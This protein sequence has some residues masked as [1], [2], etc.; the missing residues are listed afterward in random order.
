[1]SNI[2]QS[3]RYKRRYERL[4]EQLNALCG[5]D[6]IFRGVR[7]VAAPC[8][9]GTAY[10]VEVRVLGTVDTYENIVF[11]QRDS[12]YSED[13]MAVIGYEV[14]KRLRDRIRNA[15]AALR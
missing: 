3:D 11:V 13:V 7:F 5:S 4:I 1:M 14:R 2:S 12:T 6:V 10:R 15:R 8:P 9:K